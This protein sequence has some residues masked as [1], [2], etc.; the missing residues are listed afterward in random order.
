MLSKVVYRLGMLGFA[1][2][3]RTITRNRDEDAITLM[4]WIAF[5]LWGLNVVN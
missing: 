5:G 1:D 4:I 3:P 2:Y